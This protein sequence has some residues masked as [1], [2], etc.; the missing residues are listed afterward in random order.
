MN[1]ILIIIFLLIII[2]SLS[3]VEKFTEVLGTDEQKSILIDLFNVMNDI[4]E[5]IGIYPF[6]NKQTL[7]NYYIHHDILHTWDTMN[8]GIID[9]D[10]YKLKTSIHDEMVDPT[11]IYAISDTDTYKNVIIKHKN[12]G[13]YITISVYQNTNNGI[14]LHDNCIGEFASPTIIYPL[15]EDIVY[16]RKIYYPNQ[17]QFL[18]NCS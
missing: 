8:F 13:L 2:F 11:Y 15:R 14:R 5:R 12:T 1:K 7:I 4:C 10:F 18:I 3:K 9:S 17:T 16:G 6:L